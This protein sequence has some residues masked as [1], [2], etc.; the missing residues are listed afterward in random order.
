MRRSGIA[1]L[2]VAAASSVF[3]L[4]VSIVLGLGD[5][6]A[7]A[8][9]SPLGAVVQAEYG[10]AVD[11]ADG[12]VVVNRSGVWRTVDSGATW[13][14][15][16]P[17]SLRRLVDHVAKVIAIG[18]DI[19]LEMEGGHLF[20]FLP[21]SR[22]GGHSWQFARITGT[23]QMSGL[24]FGNQ[25]DGWVTGTTSNY[26][27]V[28]YRT[29]D[30]GMSWRRSGRRPKITV[31]A[32][33]SGMRASTHGSVPADLKITSAVRSP[34][35]PSWALASGPAIGSYCPTYLLRSNDGGRAWTAVRSADAQLSMRQVSIYLTTV[36]TLAP[37]S[38]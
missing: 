23:V 29:T 35:G 2:V 24:V 16:T 8:A 31:P 34:G 19:W 17:K 21:Y 36:V 3:V 20:G 25:R 33:V 28:Q 26:K 6:S 30:G 5:D 1:V 7:V 27:Q 22:D 15:I 10:M 13:T 18:P 12:L 4:V 11:G 38:R 32:A 9:S 14:N 37:G